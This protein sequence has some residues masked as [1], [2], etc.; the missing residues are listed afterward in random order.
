LSLDFRDVFD[1]GFDFDEAKGTFHLE[2]GTAR[3]DDVELS[4]TVAKISFSGSTDLVAQRYDQLM[5]VRPGVGNTLPIIGAIAGGPAGAAAG[6]A[7]QGL[8]QKQLGAAMQVQYTITGTWD[9]PVIEQVDT[10]DPGGQ[11]HPGE[12]E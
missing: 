5:T 2:N 1:S 11:S 4:S 10:D 12:N 6:A 8:F 7:L 3:T 9:E